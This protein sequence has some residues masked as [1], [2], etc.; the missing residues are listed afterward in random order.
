MLLCTCVVSF[1]LRLSE[2]SF[3]KLDYNSGVLFKIINLLK[4]KTIN[5]MHICTV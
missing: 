2:L 1:V 5:H 3:K 4:N